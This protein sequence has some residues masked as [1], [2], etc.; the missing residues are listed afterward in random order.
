MLALDHR[1]RLR[2]SFSRRL[3]PR[4]PTADS[5]ALVLLEIDAECAR[6][7]ERLHALESGGP[8]GGREN[9]APPLELSPPKDS[10]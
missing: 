4:D 7:T 8:L 2:R 9:A 1:V 5:I 6:W 10:A 3:R